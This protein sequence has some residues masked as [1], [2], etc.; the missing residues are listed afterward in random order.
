M[1]RTVLLILL[2]FLHSLATAQPTPA[3]VHS[4]VKQAGGADNFLMEM[5]RQTSPK[6]P[7]MMNQNLQVQSI[8]A[9]GRRLAYTVMLVNIDKRQGQ[10]I[11]DLRRQSISYLGCHSPTLGVLIMQYDAEIV[12]LYTARNTEFLFQHSLNRKSCESR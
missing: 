4:A 1:L 6:L 3:Q 11:D 9:N 10:S 5:A 8:A 2:T 7:Q 12:Y